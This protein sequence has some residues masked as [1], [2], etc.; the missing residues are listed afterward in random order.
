MTGGETI[1]T[2]PKMSNPESFIDE[3][4]DEVRRDNLYKSLRRY[5][6]IG[7]VAVVG[8]VGGASW[9]EWNNAKQETAAQALGDAVISAMDAEGTAGL[10][11]VAADGAA[12]SVLALLTAARSGENDA[13]TAAREALNALAVDMSADAVY[14]DLAALK[15]VMLTAG[16]T[17]AA[18][19]IAT[20]TPLAA[21]GAPYRMLAEEQ[22]AL[23]EAEAGDVEAAIIRLNQLN[24]DSE[25]TPGLRQRVSQLIV[26]L[27]GT[28]E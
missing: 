20:L 7:I 27:G 23:A 1:A 9:N 4:N 10:E 22:I 14:R 5:G 13:A 28:V 2:R 11:T 16:E 3:V 18:E 21:P 15:L 6:W 24:D 12:A 19:R 26:A 25:A 8:L 17:S